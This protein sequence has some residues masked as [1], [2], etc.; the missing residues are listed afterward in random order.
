MLKRINLPIAIAIIVV[1]VVGTIWIFNMRRLSDYIQNPEKDDIYILEGENIYH[2]LKVTGFDEREIH[3]YMYRFTFAEAVPDREMLLNYE[4]DRT[5]NATYT[6]K[7][8]QRLYDEG[9]IVEIYRD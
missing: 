4:W 7:E 5:L 2:P 6:R 3:Y 8:V 1:V 9:K